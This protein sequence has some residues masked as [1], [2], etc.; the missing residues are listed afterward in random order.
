MELSPEQARESEFSPLGTT[1]IISYGWIK[2]FIFCELRG[3]RVSF[4]LLLT[5]KNLNT[6]NTGEDATVLLP[7]FPYL[8]DMHTYANYVARST[9]EIDPK[10]REYAD[11]GNQTSASQTGVLNSTELLN[12]D[13]P[14]DEPVRV[15]FPI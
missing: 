8:H 7:D 1:Q 4:F 11:A 5:L 14:L 10:L 12:R 13:V 15:R 3:H 2:F 9:G 6:E